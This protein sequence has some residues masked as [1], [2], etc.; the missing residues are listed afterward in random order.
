MIEYLNAAEHADVFLSLFNCY[1][2]ELSTYNPKIRC[3]KNA[4]FEPQVAQKL[5]SGEC[6]NLLIRSNGKWAG[7]VITGSGGVNDCEWHIEELFILPAFRRRGIGEAA[8]DYALGGKYGRCSLHVLK[9]N[10]QAI[11]FWRKYIRSK[12][13]VYVHG[14]DCALAYYMIFRLGDNVG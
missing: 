3:D 7:F 11:L 14:E 1:L 10:K 13:G 5:L 4:Q 12:S 2:C 9:Q 8:V 6:E